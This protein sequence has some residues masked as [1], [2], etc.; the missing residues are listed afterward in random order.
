MIIEGGIIAAGVTLWGLYKYESNPATQF[1]RIVNDAMNRAGLKFKFK[2]V[3]GREV[4]EFPVLLDMSPTEFGWKTVYKL[5]VGM[6]P[7]DVVGAK[8]VLQGATNAEMDI[9]YEGQIVT[10]NFYTHKIPEPGSP[11]AM[12]SHELIE[13]VKNYPLAIP[14]G[15]SKI[16]L[17]VH[18]LSEGSAPHASVGG[19]TGMGKSNMLNLIITV[20]VKAYTDEHVHIHLVDTKMVEFFKFK[21]LSHV[22]SCSIDI[23]EG[24]ESVESLRQELRKRQ[25][26]L[27][28]E[29]YS[30]IMNF[31]R[32][33]EPEER[34]P[35]VLLIIDEYG[36]FQG[37]KE[38]WSPVDEIARKGRAMGIHLILS[39]QRPDANTLPPKVKANL[40][41]TICLKTKTKSN[42]QILLDSNK[43]FHLPLK[44]GRA[45]FQLDGLRELQIPYIDERTM[46]QEL[47]IMINKRIRK[48]DGQVVV[49][50]PSERNYDNV[51]DVTPE[52]AQSTN[53][54]GT[55]K[56]YLNPNLTSKSQEVATR[57]N[58]QQTPLPHNNNNDK[59]NNEDKIDKI[60][61]IERLEAEAYTLNTELNDLGKELYETH[62]KY[63]N[64]SDE[65]LKAELS[66]KGLGIRES[67]VNL[68]NQR[69]ELLIKS[70]TLRESLGKL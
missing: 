48:R 66:K 62:A 10:I 56:L 45:L 35:F 50:D 42:S 54:E 34:L 61:E 39:T 24:V 70:K 8:D 57:Q 43:A 37:V 36:D 21:N 4:T 31:N 47:G 18:D 29:G 3:N 58:R 7:D 30:N 67:Y 22:K 63:N 60:K 11:N 17:L 1:R 15:H 32:D 44:K 33:V 23:A 69:E 5:P 40:A 27:M 38:F 41:A 19:Q 28:S 14:V 64:E 59:T 25:K 68:R 2:S 52:F 53:S 51:I 46:E 26:I 6:T 9:D 20:L 12:Y 16:G 13:E 55:A 65:K 49:L